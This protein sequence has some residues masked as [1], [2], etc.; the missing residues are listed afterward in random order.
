MKRIFE[1]SCIPCFLIYLKFSDNPGLRKQTASP[2][3]IP[4]FVPPNERRS[5]P[6]SVVNAR[7]GS[8]SE[9]AAFASLAPSIWRS[10]PMECA[11]SAITLISSTV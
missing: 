4:F 3:I 10:K 2:N 5:T 6:A 1:A 11:R 7:N 8:P 9:Q